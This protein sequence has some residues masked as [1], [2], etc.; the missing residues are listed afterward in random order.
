MPVIDGKQMTEEE[1]D[2]EW[3]EYWDVELPA[4]VRDDMAECETAWRAQGLTWSWIG[5]D[6]RDELVWLDGDWYFLEDPKRPCRRIV[7]LSLRG[8]QLRVID[9]YDKY[10]GAFDAECKGADCYCVGHPTREV[11]RYTRLPSGS[12]AVA[13]SSL[14]VTVEREG[15]LHRYGGDKIETRTRE[16]TRTAVVFQSGTPQ[17]VADQAAKTLELTGMDHADNF[18]ALLDG[19]NRCAICRR[20]L[21]DPISKLVAVG[22]ECATKYGIPHTMEAANRRLELRKKLLGC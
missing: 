1:W 22:P 15:R 19:S 4:A 6:K 5:G 9:R 18:Y 21:R 16:A 2:K 8:G 12:Y 3:K 14:R 10:H 17:E 20:T 11:H 7:R 13:A